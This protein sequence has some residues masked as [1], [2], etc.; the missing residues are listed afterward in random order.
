MAVQNQ[1]AHFEYCSNYN[2]DVIEVEVYQIIIV[3]M[4]AKNCTCQ[5]AHSNYINFF[6]TLL[7]YSSGPPLHHGMMARELVKM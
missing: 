1:R 5:G 6:V 7:N 2:C 4:L 3:W